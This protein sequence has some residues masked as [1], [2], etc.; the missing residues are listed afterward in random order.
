MVRWLTPLFAG[1][2][3]WIL[4]FS[5]RPVHV[6]VLVGKVALWQVPRVTTAPAMLPLNYPRQTASFSKTDFEQHCIL[7]TTSVQTLNATITNFKSTFLQSQLRNNVQSQLSPPNFPVYLCADRQVALGLPS[8]SQFFQRRLLSCI[9]YRISDAGGRRSK[10]TN[11]TALCQLSVWTECLNHK[12]LNG[13]KRK[14][15]PPEHHGTEWNCTPS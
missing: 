4:G 15:G 10:Q 6:K 3:P 9:R 13:S 7:P 2:P 1:L 14:W 8:W 12:K 5:P 11:L